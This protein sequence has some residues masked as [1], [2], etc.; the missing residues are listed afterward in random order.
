MY[1]QEEST[2]GKKLTAVWVFEVLEELEALWESG[3]DGELSVEG[4]LAEEEVEDGAV[5]DALRL[6]VR[7]RHRYLVQVC[8]R[9]IDNWINIIAS[10]S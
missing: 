10:K 6:P 4:V 1:R 7:V 8:N 3:K 5:V 9:K 2:K